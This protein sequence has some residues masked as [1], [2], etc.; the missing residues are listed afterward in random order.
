MHDLQRE[1]NNPDAKPT[2]MKF[3]VE[4]KRVAFNDHW[5]PFHEKP[6][7]FNFLEFLHRRNHFVGK[8]EIAE[9]LWPEQPYKARI[10]DPRLFDIARRLR[11]IME[12]CPG[13]RITLL[14][15]RL[16]YLLV[17][18]Q[19]QLPQ[20]M[21]AMDSNVNGESFSKDVW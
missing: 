10:H 17:Q 9:Y 1:L 2:M 3:D 21:A 5:I 15:G 6:I 20:G 4:R 14:S 7:L 11:G 18:D 16:G 19:S 8:K 12:E 13:N